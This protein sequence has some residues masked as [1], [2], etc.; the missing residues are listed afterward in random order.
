MPKLESL[1]I[2][3]GFK[4]FVLAEKQA[5]KMFLEGAEQVRETLMQ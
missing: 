4:I 1:V 2:H 5:L 3:R